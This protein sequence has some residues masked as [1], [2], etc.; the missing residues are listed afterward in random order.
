MTM[1]VLIEDGR[2]TQLSLGPRTITQSLLR[3]LRKEL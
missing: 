3:E 2:W 1:M